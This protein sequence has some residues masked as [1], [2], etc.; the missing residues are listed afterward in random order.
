VRRYKFD[1]L[2]I[3]IFINRQQSYLSIIDLKK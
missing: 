1:N 2:L 3:A